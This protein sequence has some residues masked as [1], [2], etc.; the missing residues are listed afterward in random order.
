MR[1]V[2]AIFLTGCVSQNASDYGLLFDTG[3]TKS[4][5]AGEKLFYLPLEVDELP[6]QLGSPRLN[7]INFGGG[8]P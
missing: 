6:A 5:N 8:S 7:P 3:A 2:A 4:W 1:T